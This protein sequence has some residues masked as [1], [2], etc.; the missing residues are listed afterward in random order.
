MKI[1][2]YYSIDL[3]DAKSGKV[4]RKGR[5]LVCHSLLGN[6]IAC[7]MRIRTDRQQYGIDVTGTLSYIAV[8]TY[9]AAL[10]CYNTAANSTAGLVIGT[11][12]TAVTADDYNLEAKIIHGIGSGQMQYGK[13]EYEEGC[14]QAPKV[15][16][17]SAWFR[18]TRQFINNSAGSIVVK[19]IGLIT[20]VTPYFLI[21]RDV[22]VSPVTVV[23]AQGIAV[24]YEF[25]VTV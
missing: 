21:V 13:F 9:S 20:S 2:L 15:E 1:N 18:M 17:G 5:K 7:L 11:G 23:D 10:Y 14:F 19:E 3:F 16:G 22:L 24:T 4:L 12:N 6:Y 25:R 8:S